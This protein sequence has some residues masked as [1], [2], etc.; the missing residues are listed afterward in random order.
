MTR[1]AIPR[2]TLLE[3]LVIAG[4]VAVV[5]AL[6]SPHAEQ[7]ADGDFELLLHFQG[8]SPPKSGIRVA[9]GYGQNPDTYKDYFTPGSKLS[10]EWHEPSQRDGR[11]PPIRCWYSSTPKRDWLGRIRGLS[12]PAVF[13]RLL[14][15]EYSSPGKAPKYRVIPFDRHRGEKQVELTIPRE[16]PR[17]EEAWKPNL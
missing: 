5:I 3:W 1:R 12:G 11:M 7:V 8:V 4:V 13:H 16:P 2:L 10:L 9:V 6:L 15:V 14:F 17:D